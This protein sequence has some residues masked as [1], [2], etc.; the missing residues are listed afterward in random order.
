MS[1]SENVERLLGYLI[2]QIKRIIMGLDWQK[3]TPC[4]FCFVEYQFL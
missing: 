4:G 2:F 1:Y 3:R